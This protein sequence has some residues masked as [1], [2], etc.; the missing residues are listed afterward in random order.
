MFDNKEMAIF[1]INVIATWSVALAAII[2]YNL[3]MEG[4]TISDENYVFNTFITVAITVLVTEA[5]NLIAYFVK[6]K[7]EKKDKLDKLAEDVN[8]IRPQIS[9]DITGVIGVQ[10]GGRNITSQ[11]GVYDGESLSYKI[12]KISESV[13]GIN[14]IITETAA[15]NANRLEKLSK[16][17]KEIRNKISDISDVIEDWERLIEENASLKS[18]NIQLKAEINKLNECV[19]SCECE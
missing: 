10:T 15:Y 16:K 7:V 11:I 9:N 5:I 19:E 13:N 3:I 1:Y 14:D 18:E 4:Y 8:A 2:C 6:R 12:D 17:Q